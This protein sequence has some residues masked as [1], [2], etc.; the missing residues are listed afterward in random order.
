MK[1]YTVKVKSCP[2][3]IKPTIKTLQEKL[4]SWGVKGEETLFSLELCCRELM[5]N[6]ILHGYNMSHR[7]TIH[8]QLI[9]DGSTIK[10]SVADDGRGFDWKKHNFKPGSPLEET[11]RGLCVVASVS[12][13]IEFNKA[14]NK[15]TVYLGCDSS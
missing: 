11:G 6:A 4:Q 14:G 3:N 2:K 9:K 1:N 10:L 13:K 5:S 15:I 8:I 7:G 12:K